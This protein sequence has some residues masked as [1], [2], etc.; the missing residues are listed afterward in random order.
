[1]FRLNKLLSHRMAWAITLKPE[2]NTLLQRIES[3][4]AWFVESVGQVLHQVDGGLRSCYAG[5]QGS[6]GRHTREV[7]GRGLGDIF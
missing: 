4:L 2:C 5:F 6:S 7:V 3:V 1:M